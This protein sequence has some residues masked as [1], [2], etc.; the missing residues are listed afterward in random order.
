MEGGRHS[1][2]LRS[3]S[4]IGLHPLSE[5]T[6]PH[7][8]P[9]GHSPEPKHSHESTPNRRIQPLPRIINKARRS[10][11][12]RSMSDKGHEKPNLKRSSSMGR[13]TTKSKR[14]QRM[15]KHQVHLSQ[16]RISTISRKIGNG[17]VR[18]GSVSMRR[19]RSAPGQFQ[20]RVLVVSTLLVIS[21]RFHFS[22][23]A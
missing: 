20:S 19:A 8:S 7:H 14:V 11:L 6:T 12:L 3:R 10:S 1:L 18:N 2:E 5:K 21:V 13:D 15:L 16:A 9:Q 4:E 17:V 22:I 23:S